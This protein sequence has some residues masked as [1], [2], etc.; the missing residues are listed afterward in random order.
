MESHGQGRPG[1]GGGGGIGVLLTAG[2]IGIS[3]LSSNAINW[4]GFPLS[5]C[6]FAYTTHPKTTPNPIHIP[7]KYENIM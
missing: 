7:N 2:D 4:G 6:R 5:R 1:G 3:P